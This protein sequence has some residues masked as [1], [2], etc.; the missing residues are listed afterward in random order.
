MAEQKIE[1]ERPYTQSIERLKTAGLRPTRQ[2]LAL[3]RLLFD[4]MDRHVTAE[5]LH[6]EALGSHVRVSLATVYNT[7]HQFTEAGLLREVVVEAG[8]SYFDTNTG[9]HHHFFH[10][11]SGELMDIAAEQIVLDR[12]PDAP[13]GTSIDSVD[14]II[15]VRRT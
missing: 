7:L 14:V 5:Q 11:D 9:S 2:R 8:R 1:R 10:T 4:G 6:G 12:L 13:L 15:R 3:A